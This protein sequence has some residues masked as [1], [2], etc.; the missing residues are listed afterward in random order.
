MGL[1][2]QLRSP[3]SHLADLWSI[4]DPQSATVVTAWE[5]PISGASRPFPGPLFPPR[6]PAPEARPSLLPEPAPP[7]NR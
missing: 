2:R 5:L 4:D 1:L 7:P 3:T 6:F